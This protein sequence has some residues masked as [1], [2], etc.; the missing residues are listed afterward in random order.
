MD[1]DNSPLQC[2]A[3][4]AVQWSS[5]NLKLVNCDKTKEILVSFARS[6]PFMW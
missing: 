2:A 4:E 5:D 3:N 6:K 1:A